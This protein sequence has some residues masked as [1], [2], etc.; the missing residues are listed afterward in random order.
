M[1]QSRA[2]YWA[3]ASLLF[4][5]GVAPGYAVGLIAAGQTH[6][7]WIAILAAWMG[8]E[9]IGKPLTA[10]VLRHWPLLYPFAR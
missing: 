9:I 3:K 10:G 4:V 5:L 2:E 6:S 7:W 8:M 1:S